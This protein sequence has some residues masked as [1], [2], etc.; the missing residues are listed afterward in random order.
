[1]LRARFE[2]VVI[3]CRCPHREPPSS[4]VGQSADP[5]DFSPQN[6]DTLQLQEP[7]PEGPVSVI[8][9]ALR[10]LDESRGHLDGVAQGLHRSTSDLSL[11]DQDFRDSMFSI[12]EA[13]LD[14]RETDVTE[15]GLAIKGAFGRIGGHLGNARGHLSEVGA[16]N[17]GFHEDLESISESL[18]TIRDQI[19]VP[20]A[21][22]HVDQALKDLEEADE[23]YV[24]TYLEAFQAD[25][26]SKYL[27][28]EVN[29]NLFV[30]NLIYDRPG[31]D[32]SLEARQLKNKVSSYLDWNLAKA[33]QALQGALGAN[34]RAGKE[35]SEAEESLHQALESLG[36]E[37]PPH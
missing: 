29:Y 34:G 1:M 9:S 32:V 5:I 12:D 27:Q 21:R 3:R 35:T 37:L 23:Q 2:I 31:A 6:P 28:G 7:T 10:R 19:E 17:L 33:N 11:V 15:H 18:Q 25:R 16:E 30:E 14:N 36:V 24:E 26:Q 4:E 8:R 22:E 20:E 13:V